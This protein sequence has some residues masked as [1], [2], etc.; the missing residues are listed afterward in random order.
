MPTRPARQLWYFTQGEP[1][2]PRDHDMRHGLIGL[3][4]LTLAMAG[5]GARAS[6]RVDLYQVAVPL[7]DR[8]EAAQAAAFQAAMRAVL[9]RV[10]G[11]RGADQ[12]AGLAPLLNDARRYV[13]QYRPAPDG[14]LTV[15]FDAAAIDRWLAQNGQP[16]WGRERPSTFVWL[17]VATGGGAVVTRDDTSELKMSIDVQAAERGIPLM[18]PSNA[19][20]QT[21]HVD[22][23]ALGNL[24]PSTLL[25]IARRQGADAVLIGHAANATA[26]AN[27]RWVHLFQDRS[28]EFS[29]SGQG[30]EHAADTYA[31]VFVASG[32][33]APVDI[34]VTG[35]ADV[36]AYAAVQTYL[37]S[38]TFVSRV[39]VQA[40]SGDT[41]RLRLTTRGGAD[42]LQQALKLGGRLEAVA[43]GDDGVQ[44]FRLRR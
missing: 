32:A 44:R 35:I 3:L 25:E 7:A 12:D 1:R 30:V 22:Y 20:L 41:V 5:P 28:S 36:R 31:A 15:A 33:P 9:V 10:T 16:L 34:E 43:A 26:L 29:G 23:A 24:A 18:W 40:M 14:Q 27:V 4:L 19:D 38:L 6:V 8:S 13:Q 42:S 37:E 2:L 21:N 17:A 39:A 11:R